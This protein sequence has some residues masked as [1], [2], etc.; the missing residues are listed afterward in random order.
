MV[1]VRKVKHGHWRKTHKRAIA[2]RQR[3]VR[4]GKRVAGV[5]IAKK[6]LSSGASDVEAVTRTA[7]VAV[8][9]PIAVTVHLINYIEAFDGHKASG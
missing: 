9:L 7:Q 6:G 5:F 1:A 4:T 3:I 2:G 8:L